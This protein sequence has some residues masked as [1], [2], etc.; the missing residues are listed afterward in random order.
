MGKGIALQFKKAYPENFDAY[1][2]A[3][4]AYEVQPGRMFIFDRGSMLD[5]K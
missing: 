4:R 1:Q 3:C 5:V 2:R